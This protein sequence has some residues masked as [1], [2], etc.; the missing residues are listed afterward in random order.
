MR[1]EEFERVIFSGGEATPEMR[2]HAKGCAACRALLDHA[3]VLAG[4]R[5]LDEGLDVPAS[6]A[7]GWRAR[8]RGEAAQRRPG[9]ARRLADGLLSHRN[10]M[11]GVAVAAC[12]VALIGVGAQWGGRGGAGEAYSAQRASVKSAPRLYSENTS[13]DAEYEESVMDGGLARG[14]ESGSSAQSERKIIRTAQLSLDVS[15]MD[16]A[17]AAVRERTQALG[18]TVDSCEVSGR[19]GEGRWA[20]LSLSIPSEALDGFLSGAGELGEVTREASQTADMTDR[21]YDN[22]SRLESARAQKKRLDELYAQ[23]QDMSDIIA[24]TDALYS[25]QGEMDRLTGA[26]QRIDA[27]VELSQVTLTLNEAESEA[28]RA[29]AARLRESAEEGFAS[30]GAFLQSA[31]LF[32]V[33]ALPW[34]AGIALLA[35]LVL[36][37]RRLIRRG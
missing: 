6:F 36:L 8:V 12:A 27:R 33:W 37:A 32:A 10:W 4:A 3:D 15:D 11:R 25:L 30:L 34:A 29:F 16:A 13:Y 17:V 26:N 23:A 19:R 24:I 21:Y 31:V 35:L 2:E 20:S 5:E 9:F 22:E 1:C 14:A 28:P 7:R 18:G